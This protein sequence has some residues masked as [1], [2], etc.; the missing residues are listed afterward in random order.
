MAED[1]TIVIGTSI[2]NKEFD[3]Q[4]KQLEKELN[5]FVKEEDKLLNK[6]AKLE[7]DTSKSE[8][9]LDNINKKIE[10]SYK[11][12]Q[13]EKQK[14]N[15]I[16]DYKKETPEYSK[17]SANTDKA[18]INYDSL[19]TKHADLLAKYDLQKS[20]LNEV[21]QKIDENISNQERFNSKLE[22]TRS[23][24]LG[25]HM[26]FDN[27]G[28]SIMDNVK[29]V[30]KWCLALF[31]VRSAFN[32]IRQ[33]MSAISQYNKDLSNK[34]E[35]MK[36]VFASALEP[37]IIRI[38]NLLYKMLVYVNY[39]SKA[40]FG[41][42]LFAKAQEKSLKNSV[43]QAKKLQKTLAG[44]DEMNVL[45]DN[46][47]TGIAGGGNFDFVAPEDVPIPSWLQWIADNKDKVLDFL[48]AFAILIAGI[49]IAKF[50][51]KL[52]NLAKAFLNLGKNSDGANMSLENFGKKLSTGL[53][54]S[55]FALIIGAIVDLI[56]NWDSMDSA[57]KRLDG[58][59]L[60]IGGS[61][62]VLGT[63]IRVALAAGTGGISELISM[64]VGLSAV[65]G[66]MVISLKNEKKA[67]DDVTTATDKLRAAQDLYNEAI[68][69]YSNSLD[70]YD[71][72]LK[73][74]EESTKNLEEAEKRNKM[75]G[76]EL[77]KQVDAGKLSYDKMN[78]AQKEV[79][80]AY[81][82]NQEA[83]SDLSLATENLTKKKDELSL[84]EKVGRVS[85]LEMKL[86]QE[87]Q[88][89]EF[90]RGGRAAQS[91]KDEVIDALNKGE[92]KTDEAQKVFEKAMADMD[93]DARKSFM[94]GIPDSIKEGLNP[95]N[96]ESTGSKLK[97]W[98]SGLFS[99][100]KDKFGKLASGLGFGGG[101]SSGKGNGGGGG[102]GKGFAKGGVA[103]YNLPRM[104][105][106]TGGIISR[107]GQGVPIGQAIGGER[108]IEG[109]LPLTDS[110]QM[111]LLGQSIARHMVINLT[112][113][114]QMNGRVINRELKK[115]QN[116]N[117][118]A[119]NS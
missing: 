80:N 32:V 49:K 54:I 5:K 111:D 24:T 47:T 89:E 88:N 39:I 11:K 117:D 50:I 1:G 19:L 73:K 72:A 31:S 97:K 65:L 81:I 82:K 74:V 6:K 90:L 16:P 114:N 93:D 66:G 21:N 36:L 35:S 115:I 96:F 103:Y 76:E 26:N 29:K 100:I 116:D 41:V 108:G 71:N 113:I 85:A 37:I 57:S 94:E 56:K 92:I 87:A 10:L 18:Q 62:V 109:V 52:G 44:F 84:A 67:I 9:D 70:T 15:S 45:N 13:E 105:L 104:P 118:F 107:P 14:L 95:N 33:S 30:G 69:Q 43:G 25:L 77:Q 59:L 34:I 112:N 12:L 63:T 55:G 20:S 86:S 98:F 64:V 40:W 8:R 101:I 48:K 61:F 38:V 99:D 75:T 42:D 4:I 46:G 79:Y 110:Q 83:Q 58:I 106:A 3:K 91:F 53:L 17:Q 27:V 7:I 60:G 68:N 22:E 23:K 102:G 119:T 78:E 2:E 28:K 51:G